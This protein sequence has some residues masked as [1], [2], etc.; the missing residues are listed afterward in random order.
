MGTNGDVSVIVCIVIV[1]LFCLEN[2]F[3]DSF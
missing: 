2:V 1:L 3:R